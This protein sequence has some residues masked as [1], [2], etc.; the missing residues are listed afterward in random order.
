MNIQVQ[1]LKSNLKLI[2]VPIEKSPLIYY[3]LVR[4]SLKTW[5]SSEAPSLSDSLIL[6]RD[7]MQQSIT[8]LDS[9]ED[10]HDLEDSF[11][12]ITFTPTECCVICASD[13]VERVFGS[14]LKTI[15]GAYITETEYTGMKIDGERSD[16]NTSRILY[17]SEPISEAK[18]PLFFVSTYFS[19]YA[20]LPTES[21]SKV[22][23][24]L[25]ELNFTY[26]SMEDAYVSYDCVPGEV[27]NIM[28][29][30]FG[31]DKLEVDQ[32]TNLILTGARAGC[33]M[34]ALELA[35]V[36]TMVHPPRYFSVSVHGGERTFLMDEKS[37][38]SWPRLSLLGSLTDMYTA[39]F[40]D[41][42]S[43]PADVVGVIAGV[44]KKLYDEELEMN[45]FSTYWSCTVLISNDE[46]SKANE[47]FQ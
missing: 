45:Y 20:L 15:E 7:N 43:L 34:D 9:L 21:K 18:I 10:E 41:L 27:Q 19:D 14:T 32:S 13:L 31:D 33:D 6:E 8:D 30:P 37:L 3:A 1:F 36:R 44:S 40:I 12:N 38:M 4:L 29:F 23:T 46:A 22:Q 28:P 26:S 47:L 2:S 25:E 5:T 42:R 39:M 35:L 16:K 24:L 17:L 11:F